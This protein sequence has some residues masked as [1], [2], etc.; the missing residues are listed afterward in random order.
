M[1]EAL[2][3]NNFKWK[4]AIKF[5]TNY[6]YTLLKDYETGYILEVDFTYPESLHISH[7]DYT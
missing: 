5:T 6:I 3:I 2:P 4:N 7:N 1:S